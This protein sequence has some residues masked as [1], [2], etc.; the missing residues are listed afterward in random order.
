MIDGLKNVDSQV[1]I[2]ILLVIVL[3]IAA[4]ALKKGALIITIP[5]KC[6]VGGLIIYIINIFAA[7]ISDFTIPLNPLTA[8]M[9]GLLQLP[10]IALVLMIK[11]LIYPV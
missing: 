9:I 1:L 2:F 4:A 3:A 10:G 5:I 8:S 11:Y 6:I 7:K